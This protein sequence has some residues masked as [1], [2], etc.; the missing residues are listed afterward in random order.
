MTPDIMF[1]ILLGFCI[2][3]FLSIVVARLPPYLF[4][5]WRIEAKAQLG[6]DDHV[7][8]NQ[9]WLSKI[10]KSALV[11]I[12]PFLMMVATALLTAVV[13]DTLGWTP[14]GSAMLLLTWV[15][16]MLAFIDAEHQLLPD[17]LVL[18]LVWLGLVANYFHLFVPLDSAVWGAIAG[19]L[20]LWA[21]YWGF[22]L[23]TGREGMGGG[24][25][26]LLAMIG[27]WGGWEILCLTVL[28]ASV[29]GAVCGSVMLRLKP[30]SAGATIAFGPYLAAGGFI[31]ILW[32]E[33]I[34]KAYLHATV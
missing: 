18:P 10:D 19:Y 28:A 24:D 6:Q 3:P 20:S 32:G 30:S 33:Q 8:Q 13:I 22:K 29:S 12:R 14:K 34:V 1:G 31:A 5:S 23:I 17:V 9:P 21:V 27:A 16:L 25:F 7:S 11:A 4:N 15:L 2:G 26:K